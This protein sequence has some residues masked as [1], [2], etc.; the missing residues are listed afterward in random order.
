METHQEMWPKRNSLTYKFEGNDAI[1]I[2]FLFLSC[3]NWFSHPDC[4]DFQAGTNFSAVVSTMK[5]TIGPSLMVRSMATW[6][7]YV[8]CAIF[9]YWGWKIFNLLKG[10]ARKETSQFRIITLSLTDLER[11]S[12]VLPCFCCFASCWRCIS[13]KKE[14]KQNFYSWDCF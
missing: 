10:G 8:W 9:P 3:C 5:R 13:R 7:F 14:H 1:N 6:S 4:F 2:L 12:K 11:A